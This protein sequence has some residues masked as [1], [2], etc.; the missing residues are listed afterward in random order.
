M[1]DSDKYHDGIYFTFQLFNEG[2][3]IQYYAYPTLNMYD[4]VGQQINENSHFSFLWPPVSRNQLN[5]LSNSVCVP[6]PSA[7][8]CLTPQPL[9]GN[10]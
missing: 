4:F 5:Y 10:G 1:H 3:E 2:N 9:F 7:P 8:P 6:V